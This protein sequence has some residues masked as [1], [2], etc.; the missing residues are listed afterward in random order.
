MTEVNRAM[1]ESVLDADERWNAWV[2]KGVEHDRVARTRAFGAAVLVI[3]GLTGW[4][5]AALLR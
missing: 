1:S 3:L 2:A 4:F 5:A